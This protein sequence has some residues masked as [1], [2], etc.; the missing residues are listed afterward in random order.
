[1]KKFHGPSGSGLVCLSSNSV[2]KLTVVA[3]PEVFIHQQCRRCGGMQDTHNTSPPEVS[4]SMTGI[5]SIAN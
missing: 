5:E 4:P 1:L 3:T 2:F